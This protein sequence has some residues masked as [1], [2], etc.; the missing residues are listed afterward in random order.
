MLPVILAAMFMAIFDSYV[1]NVATPSFEHD[2]GAG[3]VALELIVAGYA[4]TY[5]AGMVSG[6]RL[7]D[8]FG[9]RRLFLLGM[10]AFAVT[11]LL[12]GVSQEPWQLVVSRLLQGLAAALMVPQVL[13]LI[14]ANFR[15]AEFP[16]A[17]SWFGVTTGSSA[18][19][20]Q[21]LGGVLLK[22]DVF[23]L[24]WRVIF[25][26]NV[27]VGV[28]ACLAG[29]RLLPE[30]RSPRRTRLDPVGVIGITG[31][32]ALAL[33]PVILGRD[34][35]WPIWGWILLLAS[36]PVMV[37]ALL[38]ERNLT[39]RGGDPL[40]DVRLFHNRAFSNGLIVN[41]AFMS[42]FASFSF[43]LTLFMQDGLG[44]SPLSAGLTFAPLGVVFAITAIGSRKLAM[45]LGLRVIVLGG[46]VAAVGLAVLLGELHW[47]DGDINAGWL[48]LP[49]AVVGLGYGL[50]IPSLIGAVL[51]GVAPTQAGAVAG[52]FTTA[53]QFATSIG[54]A[55][56]G[57]LFFAVLGPVL[58]GD[59]IGG[60]EAVAAVCLALVVI[61]AALTAAM[62]AQQNR[63]ARPKAE[64]PALAG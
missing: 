22:A 42:A 7:G 9:H 17:M 38:F 19:L 57:E 37:L 41:S 34:E 10:L 58:T 12:C 56:L 3:Q 63:A 49:M 62:A 16:R 59:Y 5:A 27:P 26:V 50:I 24:G 14:H 54:V 8:I 60:A 46:V 31:A 21:V 55:L 45:R 53:Q 13:A 47:L 33:L 11:S 2:L 30:N 44:Q 39:R 32:L 6:G 40:L 36:V 1:V 61:G 28:I 25:L 15:G 35:G 48:V 18:V 64:E 29:L 4:F 23:G 51:R 43:V 52:L 20:G